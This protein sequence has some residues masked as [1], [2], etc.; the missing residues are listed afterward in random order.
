MSE[1]PSSAERLALAGRRR[2]LNSAQ[3]AVAR[4][5][6]IKGR[7]DICAFTE[8]TCEAYIRL[9]EIGARALLRWRPAILL[10]HRQHLQCLCQ[11]SIAGRQR[12]KALAP[13]SPRRM[14]A[15]HVTSVKAQMSARPLMTRSRATAC[16][17]LLRS[18]RRPAS[19]KRS[20]DDVG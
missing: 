20:A 12:S 4:D 10:W 15:S 16:C 17:T 11:S 2:D 19:A 8:V 7:A 13:I 5:R 14:Y 18:R 1:P 3:H 6:V 9:G